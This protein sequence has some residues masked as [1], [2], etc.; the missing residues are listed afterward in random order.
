V[1]DLLEKV[2]V[3][4]VYAGEL[5]TAISAWR[6]AA[7]GTSRADVKAD[8]LRQLALVEWDAGEFAEALAHADEAK[9]A[10]GDVPVGPRH[11]G[12]LQ[13][14]L[15][16]QSRCAAYDDISADMEQ[17][18]QLART[19]S[20]P[21]VDM[22][23][24][25]WRIDRS[26]W[27]G[28]Y[29]RAEEAARPAVE[30]ASVWEDAALARAYTAWGVIA[31]ASGFHREAQTRADAALRFAHSAGMP[32]LEVMPRVLSGYTRIYAGNWNEAETAADIALSLAYRTSM[33]RGIAAALL[34]HSLIHVYH[35][36]LTQARACVSEAD[37]VFG[38][39]TRLDRHIFVIADLVEALTAV[40]KQNW[41]AALAAASR[42]EH[43]TSYL[44][45]MP[46]RVLG[47][48]QLGAGDVEAAR[49]TA[50]KL[51]TI[52]PRAPL[53]QASAVRLH[54]LVT[55]G[56]D[57]AAALEMLSRAA[58]AFEVLQ[59]PY[60]A[61]L[62]WLDWATIA[63][64]SDR[65][66]AAGAVERSLVVL[67]RLGARPDVDRARRLLRESGRRPTPSP[68]VRKPGELSDREAEVA[69]LVAEGLSNADIAARLFISPRTVTTHLQNIYRRL[70]VESRT[71]LTRYVLE[72][73]TRDNNR[74]T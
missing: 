21:S 26:L 54:G 72:H 22:V 46:L 42:A 58:T 35:G 20:D 73:L 17:F 15:F 59:M 41:P 34:L 33:H 28:A 71:G 6:E 8:R 64:R 68:H 47:D 51:A 30:Y 7:S 19:A 65:G 3:A 44:S 16:L 38:K 29:D 27:E 69:R 63:A 61:A 53:S 9:A 11:I 60:D 49:R 2:A 10:L 52:G 32:T 50:E 18:E 66:S 74:N 23:I 4:A 37:A 55:A 12:V 39:G 25:I 31:L 45:G 48:A 67:D 70:D 40:R 57:S 5:G 13:A 56:T 62:T 24:H 43:G 36:D 14:R 1:P